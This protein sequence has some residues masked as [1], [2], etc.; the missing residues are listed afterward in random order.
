MKFQKD[1]VTIV[2]KSIAK[3][4]ERFPLKYLVVKNFVCLSSSEM[5]C[6][7]DPSITRA[8]RLIQSVYE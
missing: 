8:K 2:M 3:I 7:A 5:I 1:I 4:K 6:N